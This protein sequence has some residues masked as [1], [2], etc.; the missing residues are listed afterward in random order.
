[1]LDAHFADVVE[2]FN[3]V[4]FGEGAA[5]LAA[6][7]DLMSLFGAKSSITRVTRV[8]ISSSKPAFQIR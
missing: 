4:A 1:M 2:I 5:L 7:A 8:F 6:L 3:V